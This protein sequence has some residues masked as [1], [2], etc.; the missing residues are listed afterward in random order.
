MNHAYG[1]PQSCGMPQSSNL[2][3]NL[4]V[5]SVNALPAILFLIF[6]TLLSRQDNY[7]VLLALVGSVFLTVSFLFGSTVCYRIGDESPRQ[8][9]FHGLMMSTALAW[10]VALAVL[11][12]LAMTPLYMGQDNGDGTNGLAEGI[13]MV[14]LFTFT[15][16]PLVLF[17][18]AFASLGASRLYNCLLCPSKQPA[19]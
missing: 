2:V 8:K 10:I 12:C 14:I 3:S 18:A 16:S 7:Q 9:L 1:V 17:V 15:F 19:P 13:L 11:A 6:M 4:L 5:C